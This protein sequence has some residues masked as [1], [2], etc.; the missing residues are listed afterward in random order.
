MTRGR[1]FVLIE[2]LVVVAV[3]GVLAGILLPA[4]ARA[5]EAAR[6]VS[7]AN[8]LMEIGIA[9]ALYASEN[10]CRLPWSGGDGNARCLIGLE[11]HYVLTPNVFVCPSDANDRIDGFI[12]ENGN[13][14]RLTAGLRT[15]ATLRCSYEYFGAY[16]MAPIELPPLPKP[17]PKTPVMWDIVVKENIEYFN[18]IP[19]GSNVLWLD[20]SVDFMRFGEFVAT[21][22]P[23]RP[24]Y[25]EYKDPPEKLERKPDPRFPQRPAGRPGQVLMKKAS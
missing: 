6:R 21:N 19:G 2:L 1:G 14:R 18:H 22:L 16:T 5:R 12:D 13:L 17:I 7:C 15:Q 4:L 3:I 24:W 11:G 9:F 25:L 10:D 20:G 8:N 23:Y